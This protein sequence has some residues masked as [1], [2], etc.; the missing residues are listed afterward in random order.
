MGLDIVLASASPRRQELLRQ[1][2]LT[3][4]V[5]PS[6]VDEQVSE[7]MQPGDLVKYLALAKAHDVAQREPG[8][9]V[10]GSDTIVVVDD[11]VL[12]KPQNRADAI[13]M[14]RSLSGR[15]HQV[16]TGIAL[17]QGNRQLVDYEVTTVQ[18]RPLN[19][20]EIER[21]VDS[22]EPMDKAGAYG[23]QGRA[24]A[25]ISAIAGDY[26]TVV[27]LPLSRTVQMLAQFGVHVL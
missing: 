24:A 26:F 3:F 4:R 10:I 9:L 8:A 6:Q 13:D 11:R 22:G 20:G 16:M 1:V 18:F 2:G 21:Y 19:Q 7:P 12:G 15:S 17:V 27:G 5:V 14:L 23:I 25:M